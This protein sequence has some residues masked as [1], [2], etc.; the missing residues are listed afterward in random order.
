MIDVNRNIKKSR[1]VVSYRNAMEETGRV[2][3]QPENYPFPKQRSDKYYKIFMSHRI[4]AVDLF[5]S[6]FQKEMAGDIIGV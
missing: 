1:L 2:D 6:L 4:C 3:Q 5:H